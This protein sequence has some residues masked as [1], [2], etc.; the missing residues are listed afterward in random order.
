MENEVRIETAKSLKAA[1]DKTKPVTD[2]GFSATVWNNLKGD[3]RVYV[4]DKKRLAAAIFLI[5]QDGNVTAQWQ[6]GHSMTRNEL[7]AALGVK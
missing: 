3:I 7:R 6:A 4:N 2:W 1:I 5:D